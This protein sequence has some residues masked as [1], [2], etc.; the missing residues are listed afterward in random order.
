MNWRGVPLKIIQTIVNLTGSATNQGG[1]NDRCILDEWEC[2]NGCEVSVSEFDF[3]NIARNEWHGDW[4]YI[5]SPK[6]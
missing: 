6:L 2:E 3:I 5:M 1:L 4:N